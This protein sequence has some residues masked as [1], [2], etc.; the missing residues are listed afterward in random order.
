MEGHQPRELVPTP[1]WVGICCLCKGKFQVW[2]WTEKGF[3]R[4]LDSFFRDYAAFLTKY[5]KLLFICV[6]EL[7]WGVFNVSKILHMII[8]S[9][10]TLKLD[11]QC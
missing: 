8:L 11:L 7:F 1:C 5:W 6:Q 2:L 4:P 10:M 9:Q 3:G